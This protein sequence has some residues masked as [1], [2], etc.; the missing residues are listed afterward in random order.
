M[1]SLG[2]AL[3]TGK[4]GVIIGWSDSWA[5]I[6]AYS[7]CCTYEI[8]WV[9]SAEDPAWECSKCRVRFEWARGA[10]FSGVWDT[11][12]SASSV[13]QLVYLVKTWTQVAEEDV[14]VTIEG[15]P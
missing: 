14:V 11:S 12:G 4:N 9:G 2:E 3:H 7:P 15:G 8:H 6:H 1:T 13:E 10:K 5:S